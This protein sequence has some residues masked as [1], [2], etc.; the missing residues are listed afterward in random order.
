MTKYK[1]LAII[2]AR[3][4]SK[5]IPNKN[6]RK[7]LGKPLIAYAIEQARSCSFVDRLVVDTDSPKIA[8]V[9]KHYGA[10]V[11]FLRPA[12]LATDKA[13]INN[14]LIY[15]L[16]R[17]KKDENYVPDY[18]LL[19]QTT[20]PLRE[21]RD[22]EDC[23][24]LMKKTNADTILTVCPTHPQLYYMDEKQNITLVN[25]VKNRSTNTQQWRPAYILNGCFVYL[26]KTA[27]FLKQKRVIMKNTK[28]MVCDKWRSVDLDNPED[29]A[30]AELLYKNKKA[31]EA[32]IKKI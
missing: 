27:E 25:D 1:I 29:W 21:L 16:K 11:P 20:S 2:P 13:S 22:I 17:L 23:W 30:L 31:I 3:G 8:A 24:K 19:L 6:T 14:A 4:R 9:A 15:L 5:R 32:N 12:H 7:F 10:E 28:A 18:I 26:F